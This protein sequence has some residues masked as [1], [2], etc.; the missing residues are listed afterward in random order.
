MIGCGFVQNFSAVFL[1]EWLSTLG[2]GLSTDYVYN[3]CLVF[4]CYTC[5]STFS[6]IG[7]KIIS[8]YLF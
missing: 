7:A 5:L 1:A 2:S 3:F 4:S 6:T 8:L